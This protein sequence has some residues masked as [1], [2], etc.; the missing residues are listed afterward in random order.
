MLS[1]YRDTQRAWTD[2]VGRALFHLHLR[3]NH[4]TVIGFGISLLSAA[5]FVGGRTFLAGV[6]LTLAGLCDFFDGSLAR[7][8]GQVTPFGAFLDSVIDRYSDLVVLLGIV[9]LF[10]RTPHT[11]GAVVAMAGLVGSTMVSYTKARAESIG[12]ACNV[13]LMERPERMICLIAGAVLD[14]LEPALW[15]LAVLANVTALQ[16]IWHTRRAI[17]NGALLALCLSPL[18]AAPVRAEQTELERA[19]AHAV[20]AYQQGN[21]GP[22]LEAFGTEAAAKS[23]VA[24]YLGWLLADALA[25]RGDPAGA[26]AAA[27][28]I[29]ERHP[30]SRLAPGALLA[31]ATH[32]ARAGDDAGAHAALSRLLEAYPDAV[33]VPEA[34]YLLGLTAEAR[35]DRA[36]A[37]HA[38]REI[39]VIAP[40]SGWADGA[41]DRLGALLAAGLTLPGLSL[42]RRIDRAERL[43]GGGVPKT[44]AEEAERI[45]RETR[46]PG[47]AVRALRIVADAWQRLGRYGLAAQALEA[48]VGRASAGHV[49]ALRLEQARL[50]LR[51]A[52]GRTADAGRGPRERA[53]K[54]L[55]AAAA[56]AVEAEAAEAAYLRAR[57]LDELER[58]GPA[59]AAYQAVAARYPAREVAG[60][61]LWRVGWL[62]WL[63][64]D[65]R[66]A[67]QAW[68]TCA[69]LPGGRM[70]RPAALYW[71]GR[72]MEQTV[73]AA[74][75]AGLYGRVLAESPRS[76][77]GLLA[78]ARTS[79]PTGP[80]PGEARIALPD[81][82]RAALAADP[83]FAR[84]ELLRR[85]GLFELAWQELEDVVQR[86]A[87]DIV[88]LYALSG[89][90]ARE[91]RYHLAL[92]LLR[93]NFAAIAAT[94]PTTLPATFW[95]MLYPFGWR[96][97]VSAAAARVGLDPFL[98]A[99]VV[100]EE[101]SYYPRAV[102][103]AG[104]RG[105]MQLM[106]GTA[107]PMATVRG[108][109][110][111]GG[112]LLDE[113]GPNLALGA[114]F[115]AGL[116]KEF[117]DPRLALA[118]YNAGPRR[119]R[120]WWQA[121]RTSDVEAWVEQIP[122]DETRQYVKRVM[123]S[124]E[125]YRRIYG[126]SRSATAS[127]GRSEREGS[128]GRSEP[129]S[130]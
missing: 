57:A 80:A 119:A 92:R 31:A 101:S 112:E 52:A 56:S 23:P 104:A 35:G 4:L 109:E 96:E 13:G 2:P 7:V 114:S 94:G 122:F 125:E 32:A 121:R 41:G 58:V 22:A 24:D 123:L 36:G 59:L 70:Q 74:R 53:L 10:A 127:P 115:L 107:Q 8:S 45:A 39:T 102:S 6:L 83:R 98:V 61:A 67:G 28:R 47:L 29:A 130:P 108:L 84:V 14:V 66:A 88:R 9:V 97:E 79:G 26:R 75:A 124:W 81:D 78:A 25:R 69:D 120:Q 43:L 37:A 18:L 34:L 91:Q 42:P 40:A 19:W 15:V 3:P 16:R 110:F 128:G 103:R 68:E 86:S 62:A 116:M 100:R 77:Y 46:D 99:A 63:K 72:A 89:E 54:S 11:R 73:G 50:Y 106:P 65:A 117:G 55:E 49:A 44:A 48:A 82:P 105:L 71:A 21:P 129:P 111:R 60:A 113:P 126:G 30:D 64:G 20:E 27:L 93:G 118:A 85:I 76:Y 95:Q 90:Y 17:R 1:R 33:E 87:G 5:A 12:I 38:Y 51:S